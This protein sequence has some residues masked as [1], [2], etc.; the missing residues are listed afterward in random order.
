MECLAQKL[1]TI[2][3]K[4][5]RPPLDFRRLGLS[6]PKAEHRHT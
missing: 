3:A 2:K 6:N 1:G 5:L 4:S